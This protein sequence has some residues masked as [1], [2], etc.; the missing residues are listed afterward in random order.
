VTFIRSAPA[1]RTHAVPVDGELVAL[2]E[3]A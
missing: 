1:P 3:A 2:D